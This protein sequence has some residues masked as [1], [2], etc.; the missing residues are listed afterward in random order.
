MLMSLWPVRYLVALMTVTSAPSSSTGWYRGPASVLSTTTSASVS[1]AIAA[2]SSAAKP[3]FE[4]DSSHT[5]VAPS[6]A[7]RTAASLVA[8]RRVS[9]PRGRRCRSAILRMPG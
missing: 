9:M 7:S 3:G 6:I 1:A 4:G 5:T 2:M 8:T